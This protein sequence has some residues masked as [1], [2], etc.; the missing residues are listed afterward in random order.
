MKDDYVLNHHDPEEA[1]WELEA[2]DPC[3]TAGHMEELEE[4]VESVTDDRRPVVERPE[5]HP[6]VSPV[7]LGVTR[8]KKA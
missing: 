8:D 4:M 3:C 5:V 7:P 6:L 1:R 2:M